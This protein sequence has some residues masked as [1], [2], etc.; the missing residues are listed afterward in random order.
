MKKKLHCLSLVAFLALAPQMAL[1]GKADDTFN[2]A[3]TVEPTTMDTY[4]ETTR[5]GYILAR[6][7]YDCLI[8]KDTSTGEFKPSLASSFKVTDDTTLDFVLRTDV[9]FH[10]GTLM[11]ADDVVY[12]LNMVSSREYGARYQIAVDWIER[13]EKTGE[14]AVRIKMKRPSPLALEMLAGNLPIYPKA[15]YEK[16]GPAGMTTKPVGTGPYRLVEVS[17]GSRYVL[18]R[19]ADYYAGSPKGQPAIKRIVVRVLPETNTQYAELMNGSL[20][21]VWKVSPD[22]AR[23]LQS[24]PNLKVQ[25]T[26]ILRYAFIGIN[27]NFQD[28]KSPFADVRVRQAFNYAV[29]R[30]AIIKA[31]VGGSA[32]PAYAPCSH[33]QFGCTYDVDRY[34]F[35]VA[36][37]KALLAEAGYPNGFSTELMISSTPKEQA[38]VIAANLA[39]VG[40]KVT[41]NF[42]QYAPALTAWRE[43]RIPLLMGNWGSYG[44]ADAGLSI[45]NYFSGTAD[46]Q[47]KDKKV[48]DLLAKADSSMDRDLRKKDYH[49]ALKIIA[50]QAYLVPLW[51]F[52]VNTAFNASL[53]F[54]FDADEYAR[55]YT[56]K[57]N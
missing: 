26:E 7:I 15:Y 9:K 37:A 38:E 27:P 35:D 33:L 23:R 50:S 1:A 52:N 13:V 6:L 2:V 46:D 49:E 17:P 11:T 12:T 47:V 31:F 5:E 29:N 25:S 44:V 41:L 32:Q 21:W 28:K 18:E 8:E 4:K 51:T 56:A 43:G 48:I 55:F 36:K 16:A 20:D 10:D 30:P 3:F 40:I 19:F 14:N 53:D 39:A 45:S 54:K 34:E 57:W 42:Q 24:R 22:D